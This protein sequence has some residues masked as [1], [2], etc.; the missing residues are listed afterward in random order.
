LIGNWQRHKRSFVYALHPALDPI[1]CL[2]SFYR[3]IVHGH[4]TS[5]ERSGKTNCPSLMARQHQAP[6]ASNE[7]E[8]ELEAA[9]VA[10]EEA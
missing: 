8:S 7:M 9:S 5:W 10:G 3:S 4:F 1:I 6:N 2:Q